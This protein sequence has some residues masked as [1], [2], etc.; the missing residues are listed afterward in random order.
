[1]PFFVFSCQELTHFRL[2]GFNLS[3]PP[4]FD[5]L[6]SLRV[7]HLGCN[8]YELGSLESLIAGCPLLEELNIIFP[9]D[10]KSICLKNAKNLIDLSLTVNQDRVSGLIK[11]LPK[12]QRLDIESYG[13]KLYA[14]IIHPS[15]LI[16]LKYL[17]LFTL[18]MNDRGEVLYIVSVL[19]SASNL[20]ELTIQSNNY[21]GVEEPNQSEELECNSC[22]LSQL[23]TT[24][25]IPPP[26][27]KCVPP[28]SCS[29]GKAS[30]TTIVGSPPHSRYNQKVFLD[31]SETHILNGL[32]NW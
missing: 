25:G 3:V 14:D 26:P 17:E 13:N 27:R 23:Q 7:L 18:N 5:G 24:W 4:N 1:M 6:K 11:S 29:R 28:G 31:T 19:K 20:V 32:K 30:K 21:D 10:A 12:I 9:P 15:Q 8:R 22:C 16:S 2:S